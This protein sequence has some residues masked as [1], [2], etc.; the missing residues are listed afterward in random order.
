M[1]KIDNKKQSLLTIDRCDRLSIDIE[2][3]RLM[4]FRTSEWHPVVCKF[5]AFEITHTH[6]H[7]HRDR[8]GPISVTISMATLV[9]Q[10][11]ERCRNSNFFL[12]FSFIRFFCFL[13]FFFCY[14]S[15]FI[16]FPSHSEHLPSSFFSLEWIMKWISASVIDYNRGV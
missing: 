7:T 9:P 1:E 5:G 6:T 2:A 10:V 15:D 4:G 11:C 16:S 13:S 12:L 3:H 8:S 14:G